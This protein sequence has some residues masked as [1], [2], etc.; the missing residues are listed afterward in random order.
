MRVTHLDHLLLTVKSI[1]ASVDFYQKTLGMKQQN[2]ADQSV[3][4]LFGDQKINLHQAK[5]AIP[6]AAAR[7]VPGSADLCFIV[8]ST[9]DEMLSHLARLNVP[10]IE[11]P[12]RRSGATGKI[13]SVYIRDPDGNLLELSQ[14][15]TEYR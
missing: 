3:A 15:V 8:N 4:L 12:V 7:G 9:M 2:L 13:D 1:D 11:G 10:L 5:S 6:P 14:Y